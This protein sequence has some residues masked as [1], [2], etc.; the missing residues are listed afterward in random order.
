MERN[1]LIIHVNRNLIAMNA[2]DGRQR[3]V[4][5]TR[6]GRERIYSRGVKLNGYAEFIQDQP[7]LDCGARAW[8]WVHPDTEVEFVDKMTYKEALNYGSH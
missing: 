4:F 1:P 6:N 8:L 2:K 7:Q 5:I 3:P